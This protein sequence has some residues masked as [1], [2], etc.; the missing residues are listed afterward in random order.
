M[1]DVLN[2]DK[3]ALKFELDNMLVNHS[4]SNDTLEPFL[5]SGALAVLFPEVAAIV[6]FGDDKEHK[7]LWKHVKQ[8]VYQCVPVPSQRWT[9]LFHDIGKPNTF[10]RNK[11]NDVSFHGHEIVGAKMFLNGVVL[12][13][14]L[15]AQEFGEAKE[16]AWLIRNSGRIDCSTSDWS[17]SAL[18]RLDKNC[19]A[20]LPA[21]LRFTRA[22]ITTGNMTRYRN[23]LAKLDKL[24]GALDAVKTAD[25]N[26]TVLPKGL[27]NAMLVL[28]P[29]RK[30]GPWLSNDMNQLRTRVL[31]GDLERGQNI[32]YYITQIK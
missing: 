6:G 18:R 8:V 9:A 28:H 10:A 30:P 27:G 16:I 17:D 12:R 22:D 14:K 11:H 5:Q 20:R 13:T 2:S 32:A 19:G 15:W 25:D 4:S 3:R 1:I 7:D 24:L 26:R 21:L 23:H 29:D 31:D